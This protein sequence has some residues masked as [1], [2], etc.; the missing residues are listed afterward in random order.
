MTTAT[1]GETMRRGVRGEGSDRGHT[2][3]RDDRESADARLVAGLRKR[4]P[5]A[6]AS[7]QQQY[8]AGIYN[9]ALRVMRHAP[10]AE[11][12]TQDVLLRAYERLP[13]DRDVM[14]RAWLYRLTLNRCYDYLRSAARRPALAPPGREVPSPLDPYEQSELRRLLEATI[15]DL[16][17]RQRAALLLKDVHGLSLVEVADC[18][19][20][21]PGSVEV[22]LARARRAFRARYK[23]RCAAVGRPLPRSAGS[24]VALPLLPLPPGLTLPPAPL[25]VPPV[26][27]CAPPL[28]AAAGSGIGAALGLPA[29]V[30]TAVLIAAT[31]ATVGSAEVAVTQSGDRPPRPSASVTLVD[32]P[33][34]AVTAPGDSAA[35]RPSP[36]AAATTP[37]TP[38]PS[39]SPS[40]TPVPSI[41]PTAVAGPAAEQSPLGGPTPR[42]TPT[43]AETPSA[44][45]ASSPSA[46]PLPSPTA[47]PSPSPTPSP[48][49]EPTISVTPSP[50]SSP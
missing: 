36:R 8:A 7:L 15:G 12:I 38:A 50:S 3:S 6:F 24:L 31:A 37:G 11:D 10:D 48:S 29:S 43:P 9:L 30:K 1:E 20:L 40:E 19:G 21:T 35:V 5:D 45:A 22:L 2:E 42:A 4:R 44:H 23:E 16:T 17:R 14:L 32:A 26:A 25:V 27:A 34:P 47:S 13:R 41:S 28:A 46:A 33:A 49:P 18:L 39:S